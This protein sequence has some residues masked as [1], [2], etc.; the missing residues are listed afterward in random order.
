M[1][2][3]INLKKLGV[4]TTVLATS[5]S[6][7]ACGG[8]GSDGYYNNG[9]SSGNTE[10]GNTNDNNQSETDTS[11]VATHLTRALQNASG[12][13]IQLAPD[14]SK[15]Y[16][17]V[18][19]LNADNGGI[20]N[21]NIRLTIATNKFGVTS[22]NSLVATGTNGVAIFEINV[23]ELAEA[24]GSVQVTATVDGTS[25]SIP[26]TLNIKKSST[27]VSDY[28]I[29]VT[30][31][32]VIDIPDGS[33]DV[34]ATVTDAKGG[35][36]ANQSVTLNMPEAM[37]GKFIISNG[38]ATQVT[39]AEGQVKYTLKVSSDFRSDDVDAFVGKSETLTFV[40][41]DEH[42]AER[43]DTADL[44]FKVTSQLLY[45]TLSVIKPDLAVAAKSTTPVIIK[46]LAKNIQGEPLKDQ[47]VRLNFEKDELAYGVKLNNVTAKTNAQ[48]VAEFS[49]STADVTH[50]IALSE[51]GIS[52]KATYVDNSVKVSA[53]TIVGVV[54]ENVNASDPEAIQR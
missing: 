1:G 13:E 49:I 18:K 14:D 51:T 31:G 52:L 6:L 46:V 16:L 19:A 53:S 30:Q 22:T 40:L 29:S 33:V 5:I 28:N 26:Y 42:K 8:G 47:D 41:V 9:S 4:N 50:P 38:A 7:V 10:G 2:F 48:G 11:N 15:V 34:I 12:Q 45:S 27:I 37:R 36:K 39:N 23:P 44:T 21:K 17:A 35:I 43:L 32:A 24:E 54:T 3:L 25:V 20:A